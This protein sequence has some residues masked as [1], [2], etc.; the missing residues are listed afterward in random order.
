MSEKKKCEKSCQQ[1]PTAGKYEELLWVY[2]IRILQCE[3][4]KGPHVTIFVAISHL[5]RTF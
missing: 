3:F 4:G 2:S 5:Q 1:R